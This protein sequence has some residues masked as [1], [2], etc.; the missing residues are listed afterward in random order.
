[1]NE[2]HRIAEWLTR[3]AADVTSLKDANTLTKE[4]KLHRIKSSYEILS[5]MIKVAQGRAYMAGIQ[6]LGT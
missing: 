6:P 5:V 2:T 4:E 3:V 1:M